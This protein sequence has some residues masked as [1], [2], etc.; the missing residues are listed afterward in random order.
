[1]GGA[2]KIEWTDATWNPVRGCTRVSEGCRNCYA[3]TMAARFSNPDQPYHGLAERT[4]KGGRWTG[5]VRLVEEHLA[6]PLRW[7]RPRR[8]FVNSMSDLFH[9]G[10]SDADIDRVFAVMAL[11]PQHTF[12]ALTKRPERM[13]AY[14]AKLSVHAERD[15]HN[16]LP[17]RWQVRLSEAHPPGTLP[18]TKNDVYRRLGVAAKFNYDPPTPPWPL[19]NV[20]LGVSIED[21]ATA[22]ARVPILLDTPAAVRFVS[23]E[24][25]L[26]PIDLSNLSAADD[27]TIDALRRRSWETEIEEGWRGTSDTW[28]EDFLDWF[29]LAAMPTGQMHH[30]LDQVIVGGESGPG[31]RTWPGYIDAA[32]SLR[33]QCAD[34]GVAFHYKQHGHW[35]H[36]SQAPHLPPGIFDLDAYRY[37]SAADSYAIGKKAAGRLLDG[38]EHN[39]MPR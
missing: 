30:V 6:D 19:P 11:A 17:G 2:S 24:P 15:R 13:R 34:A 29:N 26:G 8:I 1:M 5:K 38:V 16:C 39:G 31:A 7:R 10:L 3:E 4:A 22:D 28:E 12:Q 25:L 27:G 23:A 18:I 32:R 35:L 14:L 9:E 33:D 21:Q 20:W 36:S 37:D